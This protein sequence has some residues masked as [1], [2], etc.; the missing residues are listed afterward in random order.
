MRV[1]PLIAAAADAIGL[2]PA[3]TGAEVAEAHTA[4]TLL[5]PYL[6]TLAVAF[7]VALVA[8]P[9]MRKLA[10]MNGV[11]DWP[12]A[13]RKNHARP[14]AYLGGVGIFL[15]WFAGIVMAFTIPAAAA[16]AEVLLAFLFGAAAIH[17]TGLFD[18][19][20]AIR[21]RVKIGGQLFAAAALASQDVGVSLTRRVLEGFNVPLYELQGIVIPFTGVPLDEIVATALGTF[22]IAVF[23]LGF[24]NAVNLIDGLDGLASGVTGIAM[25]GFLI[26]SLMVSL[27]GGA[28]DA[29][30]GLDSAT[31]ALVLPFLWDPLRFTLCLA[32]IGAI[33]GFL[34]YNF[35]PASIFMGDAGSLLLGY[36]GAAAILSFSDTGGF[37]LHYVVGAMIIFAIPITDTTLAIVRRKL[38]GYPIFAPD[39]EHIH[40]LLRRAGLSVKQAVLVLYA[41]AAGLVVVGCLI[42]WNAFPLRIVL[43][44]VAVVYVGVTLVNLRLGRLLLEREQAA[45]RGTPAADP[46]ASGAASSGAAS[47]T[48]ETEPHVA[49][50]LA[51]AEAV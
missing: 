37:S 46:P 14:V 49:E 34:P 43:P 47:T 35:N 22:A 5:L 11:V 12:D 13:R 16:S 40:H 1:S 3:G 15:G 23:V 42:A 25:V 33:L 32:T 20:L 36:L 45:A 2:P 6:P 17:L 48:A 39:N 24:C 18:D 8:T 4:W 28:T 10:V 29:P 38:R 27:Q 26:L 31:D 51:A 9:I 7:V 30:G 44:T 50:E 19:V 41:V 21:A